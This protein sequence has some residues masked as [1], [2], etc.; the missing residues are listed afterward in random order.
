MRTVTAQ[1]FNALDQSERTPIL[2][3][4]VAAGIGPQHVR[5]C[6]LDDD[7]CVTRAVVY[8]LNE[9]GDRYWDFETDDAAVRTV[10]P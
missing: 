3:A 2:A 1:E 6:D 8:R 5:E 10:Y 4:L 7:G 9:G